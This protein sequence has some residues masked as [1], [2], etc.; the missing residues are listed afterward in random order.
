[1]GARAE[2]AFAPRLLGHA[3][4]AAY[5]GVSPT[6][7]RGLPIPRRVLGGRRLFDRLD[8]DRYASDLPYEGDSQAANEVDECDRH[9][10]LKG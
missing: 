7:L 9:F 4:A 5:L 1:M 8:L 3:E 6:T 10:G 2:L